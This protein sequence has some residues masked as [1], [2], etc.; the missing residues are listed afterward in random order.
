[1]NLTRSMT[2]E[3]T[4]TYTTAPSFM[5]S[6]VRQLWGWTGDNRLVRGGMPVPYS[7]L[8]VCSECATGPENIETIRVAAIR[9]LSR[10]RETGNPGDFIEVTE[11]ADGGYIRY[12]CHKCGK[13][14]GET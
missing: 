3:V 10:C 14:A 9:N 2:I 7:D 6:G 13:K 5:P 11:A 4:A 12:K 8:C 1:V